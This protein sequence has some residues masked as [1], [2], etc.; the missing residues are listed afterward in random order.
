ME[1]IIGIVVMLVG[2]IV[3]WVIYTALLWIMIKIQ[4]LNY[5]F[6]GLI[7]SSALASAI[8]YVPV[9]GPYVAA[10]VLVLCLWK[11]TG[12]EIAPDIMFTVS[13]AGAL[14]FC[15]NLFI[16]GALMGELHFAGYKSV[17][18]GNAANGIE[19]A[20]ADAMDDDDDA[21]AVEIKSVVKPA[22]P[23]AVAPVKTVHHPIETKPAAANVKPGPVVPLVKPAA[24]IVDDGIRDASSLPAKL[25]LKGLAVHSAQRTAMITD[26]KELHTIGVGDF[27]SVP[28]PK[29]NLL[30]RCED[31]NSRGVIL[32][33]E[34]GERVRLSFQ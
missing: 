8:D 15:A 1:H 10:A 22:A 33:L 34:K 9:V 11:V 29:G 13:I 31:I 28:S 27:F 25:S 26:G 14:M 24:A 30:L 18:K 2:G 3:H 16:L 32:A 5:N 12:A 19:L 17:S 23:A 21:E 6:L 7:G 4:K 20:D